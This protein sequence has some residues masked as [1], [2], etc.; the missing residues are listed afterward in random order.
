VPSDRPNILVIFTDQ[1]RTDTLSCYDPDSICQTPHLDAI[2]EQST[3][4]H[5][6][7]TVCAVC[8]PA[9]ASLQTGLY[10][11]KHGVETNIYNAGCRVH[12]LPDTDYLLSRR[13]EQ[14]G[15]SAGYTGKWHIGEGGAEAHKNTKGLRHFIAPAYSGMPTALGYV[16]DDF[17]GHGGGGYH[18]PQFKNYLTQNDLSFDVADKNNYGG[19][20]TTTGE[21]TSPLESTNE[22]FL[23]EQAIHYIKQFRGLD[24]PFCFQL[25]FWGPHEPFFAPI[26]F[27]DLYRDVEIPPWENF[28]DD[29]SG[30]PTF[31]ER[32]RRADKPWSFW[33]NS[34]RHY[35][36]FMSSIDAQIG[37]L[38][39][40]LKE[41]DLYDNTAIV[42]SADHGD[43]QGCHGGIEN[44]SY[45]MYEET[46]RIP[47]FIKPARAGSARNDVNAL[48]NTCDIYASVLD[49]AGVAPELRNEQDGRS[50][51][52]FV[53]GE[54]PADWRQSQVSEGLSCTGILCTH[55]MIR[56]GDWKYVFYASGTDELYNLRA[57]PWENTNLIDDP[58]HAKELKKLQQSLYQWMEET[59]D[60]I[61]GDL[62]HLR[63]ELT[64]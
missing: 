38:V 26:E 44:K 54:A 20:H 22:Y 63:P 27:L 49:L 13:L 2:A 30:K 29:G 53:N 59:K 57:D 33:E 42:F 8:S 45:H 18:Y 25:H 15:Y 17:P 12:E 16:G 1:H 39:V 40:Y 21:V 64:Q 46:I 34:L 5:E 23:V 60:Q 3:V 10:P 41:N 35:Y 7:Y 43:S 62:Q 19:G 37:R 11:H 47:L 51:V 52:S 6:A 36:G 32:F 61:R 4:F 55:R 28:S 58:D 14:A 9:R 24:K 48:V 50:L 56:E 31:H